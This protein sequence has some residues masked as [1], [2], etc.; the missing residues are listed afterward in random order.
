NLPFVAHTLKI[1]PFVCCLLHRDSQNWPQ[2]ICPAM[3]I[4]EFDHTRS[5]HFIMEEPKVAL[6]FKS[7]DIILFLSS[8][9]THGNA[10][11]QPGERRMSW[12]CWMVGGLLRWLAAGCALLST[13]T[14]RAKQERY[15]AR[16]QE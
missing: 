13:L 3:A 1:G 7:G 11:L 14:T 10:P 9:I 16:A 5:G 4:S 15:S 6:E 12:T 8:L 2:G